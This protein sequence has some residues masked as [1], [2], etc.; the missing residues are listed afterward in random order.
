ML[1]ASDNS[2]MQ[3]HC[4]H[5]LAIIN[6]TISFAIT[7]H[8]VFLFYSK[9]EWKRMDIHKLRAFATSQHNISRDITIVMLVKELPPSNRYLQM[10]EYL[11]H[12]SN[13]SLSCI[14]ITF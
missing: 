12:V 6:L 14:L 9:F 7:K 5:L 11:V 2:A 13:R 3:E 4:K 8:F 10:K 1:Q